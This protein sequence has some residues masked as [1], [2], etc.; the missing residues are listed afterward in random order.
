MAR[1]ASGRRHA[2]AVFQIALETGKVEQWRSELKTITA[3]LSDPQLLTVLGSPKVQLNEKLKLADACLPGLSQ[4]ATN[5]VHLLI[6]RQRLG[7][8][9]D[10][11]AEYGRM[12]DAHEGVEH[13]RVTTALPLT[14]EEQERVTQRL[15]SLTGKRIELTPDVDPSIVGG[16]IARIGDQ[17]IDGSTKTRLQTLRKELE[18]A[19]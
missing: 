3:T 13:A 8:L 18:K 17:L 10:M 12:A 6:S 15:G 16:F 5:L 4:T 14:K 1:V 7:I 2:K 9:N 19:G 11:V